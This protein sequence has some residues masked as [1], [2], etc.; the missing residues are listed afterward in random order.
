M[1][2]WIFLVMVA[3]FLLLTSFTRS[4]VVE[5]TI[6]YENVT[7]TTSTS[8]TSSIPT[9]TTTTGGGG[10]VMETTTTIALAEERRASL[11]YEMPASFEIF[12]NDTVSFTVMVKNLGTVNL[13]N[14]TLQ[15]SGI[16]SNSFTIRPTLIDLIEPGFASH[17]TVSIDSTHL[18]PGNY[19]LTLTFISTEASE[20]TTLLLIVKQYTKEIGEKLEEVKKYE[21][22]RKAWTTFK[23]LFI[24]I[25]I[26]AIILLGVIL[27]FH[28]ALRCP[29]CGTKLKKEYEDKNFAYYKCLV[30]GYRRVKLKR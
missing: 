17:F 13:T 28:R 27:Y 15:L 19:T 14:I 16:P 6:E 30:C 25:L 24:S 9:T 3:T 4:T 7:T 22:A 11:G 12:K 21:E 5:I 8:T 26:V 1:K 2:K 20:T 23:F 18:E 29:V 10:I